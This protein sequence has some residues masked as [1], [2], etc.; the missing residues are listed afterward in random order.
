M[1][2]I[3][4]LAEAN[5][6]LVTTSQLVDAGIPR[7]RIS[8]MVKAGELERVHRGVYCL[9]DAWEDEF[10]AAQLRFPKGVFSDGTS[11]YLHGFTDRTPF[12]LTMTFP[13]NA[14]QIPIYHYAKNTGRPR[15]TP[16]A[17]Y[18][19]CYLDSP[20]EPL[21]P[22]GYGLSYTDFSYSPVTLSKEAFSGKDAL[23]VSV[24]VTNTGT[25]EGI[26]TV[27]LYI[28][29][30]VGSVTRPVRQLKGF[31]RVKLAPGESR[32]ISFTITAET[33]SFYR[34]DMSFGPESGDFM[35][36]VGPSSAA[37][38]GKKFNY[39]TGR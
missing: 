7:A 15:V 31:E 9:A 38:E 30:L 32:D 14:G 8:D 22:F 25:R 36:Y 19:S 29:D 34:Q 18:E 4:D 5:G 35:V 26:E 37:G 1:Q 24:R 6:G 13:R 11:L 10:L 21:Y 28:R 27:Q 16:G 20:N 12:A 39:T 2:A 33:L 23:T 3:V 17:K